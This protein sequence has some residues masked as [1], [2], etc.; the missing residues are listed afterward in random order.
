MAMQSL[1]DVTVSSQKR[2][3]PRRLAIVVGVIGIIAAC[4]EYRNRKRRLELSDGRRMTLVHESWVEP[5][6]QHAFPGPT[7]N[8]FTRAWGELIGKPLGNTGSESMG[9]ERDYRALGLWFRLPGGW[10]PDD[11]SRL[12]PVLTDANGWKHAGL[13]FHPIGDATSQLVLLEIPSVPRAGEPSRIEVVNREGLVVGSMNYTMPAD[14]KPHFSWTTSPLPTPVQQAEM[15]VTLKGLSVGLPLGAEFSNTTTALH[16]KLYRL[17]PDFDVQVND[18]PTNEW[19]P[20]DDDWWQV[21]RHSAPV[22]NAS[23]ERS[24]IANCSLSPYDE[25]WR[26]D[27]ALAKKPS[28]L[29]AEQRVEF[30]C[31][32]PAANRADVLDNEQKIGLASIKVLGITGSGNTVLTTTGPRF[33]PGP[34]AYDW[35]KT[36]TRK[37][38]ISWSELPG[39]LPP[40]GIGF[41]SPEPDSYLYEN[42]LRPAK[43]ELTFEQPVPAIVMNVTPWKYE[44]LSLE[45]FDDQG[46]ELAGQKSRYLEVALWMPSA[47]LSPDIK[48]LTIRATLQEPKRFEFFVAP[49]KQAILDYLATQ[50]DR[51]T[52]RLS[53]TIP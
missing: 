39:A 19:Q 47:P 14:S 30:R 10:K 16:S 18:Q 28:A 24:S 37:I 50:G 29:P 53:R 9:Y 36:A 23:G 31:D 35:I 27:L 20:C 38:N 43:L 6:G 7:N 8:R 2:R 49:P 15:R 45:V 32:I 12:F 3:W 44:H 52:P 41:L 13:S 17:I 46:R 25:V 11:M 34:F 51:S 5:G 21:R 48:S 26:L 33:F 4:V 22:R 1:N 42:M 40:G